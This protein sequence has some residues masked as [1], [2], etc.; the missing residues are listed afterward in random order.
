MDVLEHLEEEHRKVEQMI[1]RLEASSSADE[2]RSILADLG[3]S[4][5]T[6]MAVEEER[7]RQDDPPSPEERESE[8]AEKRRRNR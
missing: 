4:L 6:H 2:R 5:S 3:D 7:M 1:A 8:S